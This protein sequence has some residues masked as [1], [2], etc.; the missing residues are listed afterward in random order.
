[1]HMRMAHTRMGYDPM[2]TRQM[3]HIA[4]VRSYCPIRVWASDMSIHG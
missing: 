4:I 1:M 3:G 2:H